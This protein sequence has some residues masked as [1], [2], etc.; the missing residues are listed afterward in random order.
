MSIVLSIL[1]ILVTTYIIFALLLFFMQRRLLYLPQEGLQNVDAPEIEFKNDDIVLRGWVV[2]EGNEKAILYYGGN[3]ETIEANIAFYRENFPE[4]TLYLINYRGFGKSDGNPTEENL[5]KD[6]LFIYDQ[7][8]SKYEKISLI[9]RSLGT[10][11]ATYVASKRNIDKLVLITPFDSI[12]NVAKETYKIFPFSL[13]LKDKYESIN[14]VKDINS[15]TIFIIAEKDRMIKNSL[16][17]NLY[18]AF[19]K[20]IVEL[21]IIKDAGHNSISHYT[22]FTE[23]MKNFLKY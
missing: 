6:A 9:G 4:Y 3:A 2:N 1:K 23:S 5:F 13:L 11:I 19:N 20:E 22:E 7:L 17:M 14:Y 12:L 16:S 21:S 8:S 15:K 18:E 10:G